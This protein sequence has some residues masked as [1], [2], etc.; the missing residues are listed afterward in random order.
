MRKVLALLLIVGILLGTFAVIEGISEIS[1]EENVDFS[2][3]ELQGGGI[4]DPAPCGGG[5]DGGG[6]IPG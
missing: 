4:G 3:D 2:D 1:C 6:G 5:S